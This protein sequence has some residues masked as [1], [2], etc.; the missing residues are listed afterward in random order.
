ALCGMVRQN[1][2]EPG[3]NPLQ[4]GY[5]KLSGFPCCH[6]VVGTAAFLYRRACRASTTKRPGD[7]HGHVAEWLRSGLQNRLPQ[8]NSGRGLHNLAKVRLGTST[9]SQQRSPQTTGTT[10]VPAC[11]ICA[12]SAS[13]QGEGRWNYG[14]PITLS[15]LAFSILKVARGR[16]HTGRK[17]VPRRVAN[18]AMGFCRFDYRAS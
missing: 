9:L 16:R 7:T 5:A 14:S 1:A 15:L 6:T 13:A 17:L 2:R 11:R 12:R 3:A 10:R 18:L 4:A 8:F